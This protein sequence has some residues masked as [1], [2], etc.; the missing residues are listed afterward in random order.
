MG[1]YYGDESVLDKVKR[2]DNSAHNVHD[3]LLTYYKHCVECE[4]FID[5][6]HLKITSITCCPASIDFGWDFCVK[7]TEQLRMH[8][9]VAVIEWMNTFMIQVSAINKKSKLP[10]WQPFPFPLK[11]YYISKLS[12][13]VDHFY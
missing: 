6:S 13:I 5:Q 10:N 8:A 1:L 11:I 2:V 9:M 7:M 4:R 12:V 3:P